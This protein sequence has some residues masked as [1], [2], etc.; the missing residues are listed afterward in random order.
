MVLFKRPFF[1]RNNKNQN[2]V[3]FSLNIYRLNWN[4][5]NNRFLRQ[6]ISLL[7]V[8][9]PFLGSCELPKKQ[10]PK[11]L[12]LSHKIKLTNPYI[13]ATLDWVSKLLGVENQSLWQRFNSLLTPWWHFFIK[14][15]KTTSIPPLF[16]YYCN[17]KVFH[18]KF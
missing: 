16:S 15:R 12:G 3:F 9:K 18:E 6:N 4:W 8:H 10:F 14:K 7:N 11:E 5:K 17:L 2:F 13:F 1:L